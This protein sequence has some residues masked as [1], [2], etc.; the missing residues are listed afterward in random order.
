[1]FLGVLSRCAWARAIHS[2]TPGRP[3]DERLRLLLTQLVQRGRA[4]G[5][6]GAG[7]RASTRGDGG[8]TGKSA[9]R[10]R[11]RCMPVRRRC[12]L[13]RLYAL[14]LAAVYMCVCVCVFA[15]V[16]VFALQLP[17][18]RVYKS[19]YSCLQSLSVAG[20]CDL[21]RRNQ[22]SYQ[23]GFVFSVT[24]ASIFACPNR[25]PI[26]TVESSAHSNAMRASQDFALRR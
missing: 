2:V 25:A 13:V 17:T 26:W 21:L 20:N 3:T 8:Q 7:A 18:R 11:R 10:L 24:N 5:G 14:L 19:N 1:M 15:G 22:K 16:C 4:N 9:R 12:H 23:K 6:R